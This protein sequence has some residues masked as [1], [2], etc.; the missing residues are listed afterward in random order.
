MKSSETSSHF[1]PEQFSDPSSPFLHHTHINYPDDAP[2][3]K[4]YGGYFYMGGKIIQG[5][6]LEQ[7]RFVSISDFKWCM[8]CGGEVEF[9]WAG[10][11]YGVS[12]TQ[13][14]II[15]YLYNQPDTTKYFSTAD[16]ALKYMVGKDRLRDVITKVT[17][18]DRTI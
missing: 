15:I 1:Y 6:T 3:F 18:I 16:D 12:H 17:V 5:N 4:K 14:K 13:E 9:D 11:K 8:N 2:K 10:Q 7:N